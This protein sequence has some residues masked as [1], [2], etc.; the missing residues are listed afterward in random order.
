[1]HSLLSRKG[2]SRRVDVNK[3]SKRESEQGLDSRFITIAP[4]YLEKLD[5]RARTLYASIVRVKDRP[6]C[7]QREW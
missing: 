5:A 2:D 3:Q 1:M 4:F 6:S 7:C